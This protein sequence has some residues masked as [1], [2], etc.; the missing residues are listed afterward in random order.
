MP[1]VPAQCRSACELAR[2]LPHGGETPSSEL[3]K[4]SLLPLLEGSS[5]ATIAGHAP[6]CG[7]DETSSQLSSAQLLHTESLGSV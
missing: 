5:Q 4:L 6:V 1:A 2:A 7:V 3:C